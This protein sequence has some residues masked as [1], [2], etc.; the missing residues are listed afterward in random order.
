M[1]ERRDDERER[2]REG[3]EWKMEESVTRGRSSTVLQYSRLYLFIYMCVCLLVD[4]NYIV[5]N[6]VISLSSRFLRLWLA[7]ISKEAE[8]IYENQ[9]S[10]FPQTTLCLSSSV[11]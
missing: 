11:W 9:E 5:S 6:D 7:I 1:D 8:E 10:N 2:K 4:G 3:R